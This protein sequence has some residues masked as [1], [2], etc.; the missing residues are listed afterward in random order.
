MPRDDQGSSVGLILASGVS[1]HVRVE[2]DAEGRALLHALGLD[3][4]ETP[5][6]FMVA[7]ARAHGWVS[8]LGWVLFINLGMILPGWGLVL[9]AE[10]VLHME[11]PGLLV[12]PV[13]LV[14]AF[15]MMS[16]LMT[17]W[18][19]MVL[20][21]RDAVETRAGRIARRVPYPSIVAA[22][23]SVDG[24]VLILTDGERVE[25]RTRAAKQ[26]VDPQRDIL[27]QCIRTAMTQSGATRVAG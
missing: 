4:S 10:H 8:Q 3:S 12:M 5:M 27:L 20:V 13:M 26:T 2:D 15:A 11:D 17:A 24:V 18:T 23:T 14:W 16:L 7:S 9:L 22:E 25:L 6:R 21:G 1:V 19:E